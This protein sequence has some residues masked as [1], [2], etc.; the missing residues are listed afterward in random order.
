MPTEFSDATALDTGTWRARVQDALSDGHTVDA[1]KMCRSYAQIH[2]DDTEAVYQL[3]VLELEAGDPQSATHH[4]RAAADTWHYAAHAYAQL[5]TALIAVNSLVEAEQAIDRA[6]LLEPKHGPAIAQKAR[7]RLH[8]GDFE[9]AVV[10]GRKAVKLLPSD[11]NS[12]VTLSQAL[13]RQGK[14]KPA[15]KVAEKAAQKFS[16]DAQ[17]QLELAQCWLSLRNDAKAEAAL[18]HAVQLQAGY[19]EALEPLAALQ[20]VRAD[21]RAC[22]TVDQIYATLLQ[23]DDSCAALRYIDAHISEPAHQTPALAAKVIAHLQRGDSAPI[24]RYL[25]FDELVLTGT[26]DAPPRYNSVTEFNQA[27]ARYC[28]QAA[29][30]S[31]SPS[32]QPEVVYAQSKELLQYNDPPMVALRHIIDQAVT[33]YRNEIISAHA[34]FPLRVV[35]DYWLQ[36]WSVVMQGAGN[37]DCHCHPPS[38]LSGVYYVDVPAAISGSPQVAD[39]ALDLNSKSNKPAGYFELGPPPDSFALS[40]SCATLMHQPQPGGFILFPSYMYHRTVPFRSEQARISFAFNVIP[41]DHPGMGGY[42]ATPEQA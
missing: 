2:P 37:K 9:N 34:D 35:D 11:P 27:L 12:H 6:L 4:I 23:Q 30:F 39:S 31:L 33:R 25:H 20:F 14:L 38:W 10:L 28:V 21:W 40:T 5:G 15:C 42:F 41:H 7:L 32:D 29:Q 1:I 36:G 8:A 19:V 17:T 3:G 26:I 18:Q 22:V 24:S 16:S 13:R